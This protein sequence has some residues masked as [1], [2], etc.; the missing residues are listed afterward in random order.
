MAATLHLTCGLPCA[1]KTTLARELERRHRAL[2]LTSDEWIR[3]L[4][5]DGSDAEFDAARLPVEGVQWDVAL[6]TLELGCDVVLDWGVWTRA[7]RTR[8]REGARRVGARVELHFL[9]LP[10]DELWLRLRRR[11]TE[12][13]PG[14]FRFGRDLLDRYALRFE[15]P[16]P[17]EL[18]SFDPPRED[19][20]AARG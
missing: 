10:V 20:P 17:G 7:E 11:N 13:P 12:A 8:C 3:R 19:R 18:A 1:G 6:R 16:S 2:R 14:T 4:W 9:D 5:P 15:R